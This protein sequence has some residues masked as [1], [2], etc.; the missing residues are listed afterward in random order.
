M[1]APYAC[2]LCCWRFGSVCCLHPHCR[3]IITKLEISIF[4]FQHPIWFYL[5]FPLVFLLARPFKTVEIGCTWTHSIDIRDVVPERTIG[6]WSGGVERFL[7]RPTRLALLPQF[8]AGWCGVSHVACRDSGGSLNG[9]YE[10]WNRP[11]T[12]VDME[13]TDGHSWHWTDR[14][15]Q[16]TLSIHHFSGY[17]A[18]GMLQWVWS[19]R[20]T[21]VDIE[22][23]DHFMGVT[24]R[25]LQ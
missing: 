9:R 2:R 1:L 10:V 3:V 21:A 20:I 25:L 23:S 12:I 8:V 22:Q 6:F 17:G 11:I 15:L 18:D 5:S 24:D 4:F 16:W 7:I 14:S 13:Q 19:R